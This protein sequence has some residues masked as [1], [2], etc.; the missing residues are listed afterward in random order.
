MIYS[1]SKFLLHGETC[2][3][4]NRHSSRHLHVNLRIYF[5]FTFMKLI[6]WLLMCD[7]FSGLVSN[8]IHFVVVFIYFFVTG[9]KICANVYFHLNCQLNVCVIFTAVDHF[10][11]SLFLCTHFAEGKKKIII[12]E[13]E[14]KE[15]GSSGENN[16]H[17]INTQMEFTHMSKSAFFLCFFLCCPLYVNKTQIKDR[18]RKQSAP[19]FVIFE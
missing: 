6:H 14:R 12:L 10:I 1:I 3:C 4:A 11:G 2:L 16:W 7:D 18:H 9:S 19:Q 5:F 8:C 17:Q 13:C 15:K